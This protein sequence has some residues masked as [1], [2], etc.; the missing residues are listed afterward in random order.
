MALRFR[1]IFSEDTFFR[2]GRVRNQGEMLHA[3]HSREIQRAGAAADLIWILYLSCRLLSELSPPRFGAE[4][5]LIRTEFVRGYQFTGVLR[6]NPATEECQ[7]PMR[8]KLPSCRTLCGN[9]KRIRALPL[10]PR[11]WKTRAVL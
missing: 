3:K 10:N 11:P 6:P 8:D 5:E 4:R 2:R 7:S 9:R 1:K